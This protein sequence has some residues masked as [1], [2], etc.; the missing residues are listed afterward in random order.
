MKIVADRCI[1]CVTEAFSIFGEIRTVDGR[2]VERPEIHDADMLLVRS[3]TPVTPQLIVE[4]NLKFIASAT[5]GIEHIDISA[6]RKQGIGFAY[7]AGSNANS[8]AQYVVAA[9]LQIAKK[10]SC[11][12]ADFVLGIIGVG[13]VGSLVKKYAEALSMRYLVNDPPKKRLSGNEIYRPLDEVLHAA[14]IVT[15]HVPLEKQGNDPT[16]HLVNSDFLT[17]MKP[18]TVLINSSR[19]QVVDEDAVK[20]SRSKLSGLVIDVWNNEPAIDPEFCAMADIATPHIAGYSYDGKI[21]G[22]EMIYRE[23]CSFFKQ[24]PLWSAS[25][26]LSESAGMID[27]T[28]ASNPVFDAVQSA[29]PI[30]R[31]D[32]ALRKAITMGDSNINFDML[33]ARYPKRLEFSHYSVRC[34]ASQIKAA[35]VLGKLGFKVAVA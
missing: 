16:Y 11:T 24:K 35:E 10:K 28:H 25:D 20:R 22:T 30:M 3:V 17:R 31:D 19:G 6:V 18:G 33:R 21:R 9:V 29:Y 23:A 7:A 13:N 32:A 2:T 15:V 34:L 14:D 27:I 4:S 26:L 12:P 1:P 5:T 8:V